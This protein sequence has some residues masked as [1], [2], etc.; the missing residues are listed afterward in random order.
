[1]PIAVGLV[2]EYERL[3]NETVA[4]NK[5]LD[6]DRARLEAGAKEYMSSC[7]IFIKSQEEKLKKDLSERRHSGQ[8]AGAPSEN[9]TGERNHGDGQ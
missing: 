1:M 3:A 7:Q 8:V 4:K 2:S 5:L 6:E 9:S